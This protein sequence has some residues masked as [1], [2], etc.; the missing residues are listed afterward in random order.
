MCEHHTLQS[1]NDRNDDILNDGTAYS[2]VHIQHLFR[3]LVHIYS[4]LEE[5]IDS[6]FY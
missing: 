4:F 6:K 2:P 1:E 3:P 5:I